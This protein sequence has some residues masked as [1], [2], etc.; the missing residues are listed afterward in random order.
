MPIMNIFSVCNLEELL[1]FLAD[2]EQFVFL[3]TVKPDAE[4]RTSLLFLN[5]VSRLQCRS[6]DDFR[7][8][9]ARIESALAAGHYVAG[10]FSYEFGYLLEENLQGLLCRSGDA[11]LLL[12]D[13]GFFAEPYF[14]DHLSGNTTFPGVNQVKNGRATDVREPLVPCHVKNIRPS[15]DRDT[16]LQAIHAIQRYIRAG[17]TYQ[18]NYTLKL[19][20]DFLGTPEALYKILRRNQS[21]AYGAYLRLGE[22][23]LLSFSPELFF[24]KDADRIMV[25]PM[26][27]TMHRGRFPDED[28]EQAQRLRN[29]VKNRSENVMIVDLLRNDLGRLMHDLGDVPVRTSSLFDVERYETLLQ[30]TSTV[31]ADGGRDCLASLTLVQLFQALFPCG[32]VTGAPKIR[33][34]EI[35][36]E[37]ETERRGVYTGAIGYLAPSGEALFNVPIRTVSLRGTQGEMGIGSGIVADSVPEQEWQECL[38]KGKF[39][40]SSTPEF[41]LIETL[42][43]EPGVGYWL[44]SDHLERLRASSDY[45]LFSFSLSSIEQQLNRKSRLFTTIPMRV[46]LALAKDGVVAITS[47]PCSLPLARRLPLHSDLRAAD[48][49][50]IEISQVRTD[51]SL[52]WYFHK[53]TRREVYDRELQRAR[54]NGLLDCCFLNERGELTEGCITN[55]ILFRKGEYVTPSL[56][57]GVLAG[58]MRK[59]LLANA[60]SSLREEVLTLDD[61]QHADAV[62]LC[63]SVRGVVQVTE[64]RDFEI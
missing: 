36:S 19:F 39:L 8:F 17:D 13:I 2:Q 30:M 41:K 46:R 15:Q 4:N 57:C 54:E 21:V 3:D 14:F 40:T 18:V 25:R 61:L 53:T 23:R 10:W 48:L 52:P 32:S 34:M 62:F 27:G 51:S 22:S 58:I 11:S 44:L 33:T 6:G 63:N 26:K 37:L 64:K 59:S 5:P 50:L 24:R 56:H 20:F 47:Q 38:L 16:Y 29:D 28:N 45:F 55:I 49:P 42:L 1:M 43:W 31:I 9:L 35:I 12:A 60:K 7:L